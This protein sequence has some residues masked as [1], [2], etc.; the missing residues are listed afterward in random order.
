MKEKVGSAGSVCQV[1]IGVAP[2]TLNEDRALVFIKILIYLFRMASKLEEK[3]V[4]F[5]MLYSIGFNITISGSP[6]RLLYGGTAISSCEKVNWATEI[7][8]SALINI[9]WSERG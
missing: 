6:R 4:M 8:L 9:A 2:F 3:T 5:L 7:G 1:S